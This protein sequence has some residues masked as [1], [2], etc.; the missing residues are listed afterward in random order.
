MPV[1][2]LDDLVAWGCLCSVISHGANNIK[3][4]RLETFPTEAN[5]FHCDV[6]NSTSLS[7]VHLIK[8]YLVFLPKWGGWQDPCEVGEQPVSGPKPM[9]IPLLLPFGWN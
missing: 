6:V 7:E 5:K 4:S 3:D 8:G 1:V 9:T 2:V